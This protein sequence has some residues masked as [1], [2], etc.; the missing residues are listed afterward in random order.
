MSTEY[1]IACLTCQEVRL[2]GKFWLARDASTEA[3]YQVMA[4]D[5]LANA[6]QRECVA[7]LV[8]FLSA[9]EDH[10]CMFISDQSDLWD[11]IEQND[12]TE[13]YPL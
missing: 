1:Y 8:S 13:D 2:L 10:H 5:L 4:E 6:G 7:W 3:E 9:H 12:W 11:D